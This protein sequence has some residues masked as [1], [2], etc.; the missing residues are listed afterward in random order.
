MKKN[1]D[2]YHKSAKDFYGENNTSYNKTLITF[3]K[4]AAVIEDQYNKAAEIFT[5]FE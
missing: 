5:L 2:F 1:I 4:E 3:Q